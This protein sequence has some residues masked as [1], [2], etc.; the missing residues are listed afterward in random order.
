MINEKKVRILGL[1]KRY[2]QII[3]ELKIYLNAHTVHVIC[4][5]DLNNLDDLIKE[6]D[7]I[8]TELNILD[9]SRNEIP[10]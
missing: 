8:K 4:K 10:F 7:A 6:R 9:P 3:N 1:E 5:V 2:E